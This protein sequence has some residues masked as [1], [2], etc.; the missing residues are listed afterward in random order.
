MT[1][2]GKYKRSKPNEYVAKA[3]PLKLPKHDATSDEESNEG[4]KEDHAVEIEKKKTAKKVQQKKAKAI[5]TK[6]KKQEG[7]VRILGSIAHLLYHNN[8]P[9]IILTKTITHE[10]HH[11]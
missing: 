6:L 2:E 8:Y 3:A 5:L 9:S 11:K 1:K 7:K 10:I 4:N